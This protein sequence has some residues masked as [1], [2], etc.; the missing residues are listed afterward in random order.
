M[1]KSKTELA[2]TGHKGTLKQVAALVDRHMTLFF[3]G[4]R[5]VPSPYLKGPPGVGKTDVVHQ[6]AEKHGAKFKDVPLII[7]DTVDMR[8]IPYVKDGT[9]RWALPG[10][11]P[12]DGKGIL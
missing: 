3:D 4:H 6:L 5:G 12:R 8:G 9:T 7:Y 2:S 11:F 10:E 1:A